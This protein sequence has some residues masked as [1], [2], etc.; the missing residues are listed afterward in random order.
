MAIPGVERP[1]RLREFVAQIVG[2][3]IDLEL[4]ESGKGL[5]GPVQGVA[6]VLNKPG[7][8]EDKLWPADDGWE[9]YQARRRELEQA[10]RNAVLAGDWQFRGRCPGSAEFRDISDDDIHFAASMDLLLDQIDQFENVIARRKAPSREER[11]REELHQ[12]MSRA[13]PKHAAWTKDKIHERLKHLIP[14]ISDGEFRSGW[15]TL[16]PKFP[17]LRKKGPP[18][19][20]NLP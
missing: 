18:I 6:A 12:I 9:V 19:R 2:R 17:E 1:L 15:E 14:D 16:S 3:P 7:E 20:S 8:F 10:V 4:L 13:V 11:V 5:R